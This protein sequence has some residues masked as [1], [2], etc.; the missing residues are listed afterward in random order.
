M[1]CRRIYFLAVCLCLLSS[2]ECNRENDSLHSAKHD[3]AL[4]Q[5][6]LDYMEGWFEGDT[7][8]VERI[9]HPRF[10]RRIAGLTVNGDD[11]FFNNTREEFLEMTRRVGDRATP[12]DKRNIHLQV[13]DQALTT[14]SVRVNSAYYTEYLSMTKMSDGWKVVNVLWEN[15]PNDKEEIPVNPDVV[16]DYAGAY[17]HASGARLNVIGKENRIYLQYPGQTPFEIFADSD[18]SFFTKGYKSSISFVR[19]PSGNVNEL[20]KH[21][22]YREIVYHRIIR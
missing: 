17:Q 5:A 15:V 7:I 8:R 20:V 16:A 3:P 1:N 10:I 11:F 12:E 9:L 13:L 21:L 2:L 22:R 19:G 4:V 18:S 6:A 14:A